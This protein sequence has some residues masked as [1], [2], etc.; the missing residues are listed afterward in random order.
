MPILGIGNAHFCANLRKHAEMASITALDRHTEL[1]LVARAQHGDAEA[2][3]TLV[4]QYEPSVSRFAT[5]MHIPG[6]DR[7]DNKQE[8]RIA[9]IESIRDFDP[10]RGVK[11]ITFVFR[12]I[13]YSHKN[14]NKTLNRDKRRIIYTPMA[15]LNEPQELSGVNG[16]PNG[17]LGDVTEGPENTSFNDIV[18]ITDMLRPLTST[19]R[20]VALFLYEGLSIREIAY[21]LERTSERISQIKA[22]IAIKLS[23][24][25]NQAESYA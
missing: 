1:E 9:I 7:C 13:I 20:A 19:E 10:G 15:S 12:T 2:M 5:Q 8:V 6:Y 4:I 23:D 11:L 14:L 16:D 17:T 18:A 3:Q 21:E 25:Q 22:N 24:P